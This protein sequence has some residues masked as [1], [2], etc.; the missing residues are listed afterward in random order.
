MTRSSRHI[1]TF[2]VRSVAKWAGLLATF[3]VA[4]AWTVSVPLLSK[5]ALSIEWVGRNNYALVSCGR[6][7][8]WR[9]RNPAAPNRL[10]LAW[11]I[12]GDW[13]G[14]LEFG[15]IA[16]RFER[17]PDGFNLTIPIWLPMMLAAVPTTILWSYDRRRIPPGHCP[18]CGYNLTLNVSGECPECGTPIHRDATLQPS[19]HPREAARR[20]PSSGPL[21]TCELRGRDGSNLADGW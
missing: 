4:A 18:K 19:A 15:L 9:P 12:P 10:G 5:R 11:W 17:T 20:I 13:P 16:P 2:R 21:L 3:S 1:L 7:D 6:V 8:W 14:G